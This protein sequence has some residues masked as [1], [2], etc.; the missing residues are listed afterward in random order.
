MKVVQV[1]EY[2]N[3]TTILQKSL[4]PSKLIM[5]R[6]ESIF[7]FFA[8]EPT[9]M[10]VQEKEN[11]DKINYS[12][13]FRIREWGIDECVSW[14]IFSSD[15]EKVDKI[16]LRKVF[17]NKKKD[18]N[19]L[20]NCNKGNYE[21]LLECWPSIKIRN[22]YISNMETEKLVQI[23]ENLDYK[24]QK[25]IRFKRNAKKKYK[26]VELLRLFDWGQIHIT[27]GGNKTIKG[28]QKQVVI[29]IKEIERLIKHEGKK[30]A[31]LIDLRYNLPI[32]LYK[33]IFA[34]N[35]YQEFY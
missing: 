6:F 8:T 32:D 18:K 25:G 9:V 33:K 5:V 16:V 15:R 7:N 34:S 29:I 23:L 12:E 22:I 24:I 4:F 17:W 1:K 10:I 20:K 28:I 13:I 19:I 14:S 21:S 3:A 11:G 27:W 26:D 35:R 31:F 2:G 30:K